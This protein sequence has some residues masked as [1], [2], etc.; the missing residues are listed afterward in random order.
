MFWSAFPV[1]LGLLGCM[2]GFRTN[3]IPGLD[4]QSSRTAQS[5]ILLH[6]GHVPELLQSTGDEDPSLGES[7][8]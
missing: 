3:C 6:S 4:L 8:P 1:Y 2:C 5:F 7:G